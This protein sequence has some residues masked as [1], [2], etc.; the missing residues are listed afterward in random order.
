M[1]LKQQLTEDMKQ[2]MRDRDSLKLNTIRFVLSEVKNKEID[3]GELDDNGVQTVIA[4]L[5]KQ[6]KDAILDF[7]SGNRAD[8]VEEEEKKV[9]VLQAYLP[10]QLDDDALRVLITEVKQEMP[11]AQ[12]GHIIGAVLKKANG[13]ADGGRVSVLVKEVL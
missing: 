2:A 11:D 3:D 13:K 5:V 8:L 1:A 7:S 6:M 9:V 10:E 4:K 12:M